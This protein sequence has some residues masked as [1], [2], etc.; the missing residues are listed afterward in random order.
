MRVTYNQGPA[1]FSVRW[2]YEGPTEDFRV[3][4]T[5]DGNNRVPNAALPRPEI[6]AWNYIDLAVG[7]DV[8]ER[9]S[10]N[11]GVNNVFDK[12]PPVLGAQAEQAN[13]LPSFFD[14][15]GRDFFMGVNF[16]F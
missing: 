14:V 4:N 5:F 7:F 1:L 6:G 3:Q 13:T 12:Q 2:R 15:L 9:M 16:R 10:F 8:T 11:A